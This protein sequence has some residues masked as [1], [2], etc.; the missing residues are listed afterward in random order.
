MLSDKIL[1]K[2]YYWCEDECR[3][4]IPENC[5]WKNCFRLR[6]YLST[7]SFQVANLEEH[8]LDPVLPNSTN[9]FIISQ[10]K[11]YL[12]I[13][14]YT[15]DNQLYPSCTF[16]WPHAYI[17]WPDLNC[18][19]LTSTESR[20]KTSQIRWKNCSESK[21]MLNWNKSNHETA[22]SWKIAWLKELLKVR[23]LLEVKKKTPAIWEE[24]H[25]KE[26]D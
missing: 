1:I 17:Q 25:K 10:N 3:Q 18:E 6:I 12:E 19:L 8:L 16:T 4:C 9:K 11:F 14:L 20:N 15:L 26:K 23:A 21:E 22:R 13:I 5:F 2:R 24:K 7:K